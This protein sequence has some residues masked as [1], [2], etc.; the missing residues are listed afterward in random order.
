MVQE[1][2]VVDL[3]VLLQDQR[4]ELLVVK[5]VL[6][7]EILLH[8]EDS[9]IRGMLGPVVVKQQLLMALIGMEVA[10]VE[11]MEA[12]LLAVV[13]VEVVSKEPVEMEEPT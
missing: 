9:D 2:L 5:E 1:V 7:G 12:E 10:L 13:E 11:Q 8:P 6:L 3:A 4:Q